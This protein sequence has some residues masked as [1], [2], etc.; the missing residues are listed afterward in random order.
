MTASER[1]KIEAA[2]L[3]LA[4]ADPARPCYG[5]TCNVDRAAVDVVDV[6]AYRPGSIKL[7]DPASTF[8]IVRRA[9]AVHPPPGCGIYPGYDYDEAHHAEGHRL[10][11]RR[12]GI[13][14]GYGTSPPDPPITPNLL[15]EVGV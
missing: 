7:Q 5:S 11:S 15:G 13:L 3:R 6:Y 8:H 9:C 1:L 2:S 14:E 4:Q 12:R 10:H